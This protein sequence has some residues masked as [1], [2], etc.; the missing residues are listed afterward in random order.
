MNFITKLYP[1]Q[2]STF[3]NKAFVIRD[4]SV[5]FVFLVHTEFR[6]GTSRLQCSRSTLSV[7][8]HIHGHIIEEQHVKIPR[9]SEDHIREPQISQQKTAAISCASAILSLCPAPCKRERR[10]KPQAFAYR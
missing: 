10:R 9:T 3:V 8:P 6:A 5:T 2:L 1:C 4:N 7:S